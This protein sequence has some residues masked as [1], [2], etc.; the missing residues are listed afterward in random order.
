[1]A[2]AGNSEETCIITQVKRDRG[3]NVAAPVGWKQETDFEGN[4]ESTILLGMGSGE[5]TV[6][7]KGG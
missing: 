5:A 6:R 3:T 7:N 4:W 1:M 2:K